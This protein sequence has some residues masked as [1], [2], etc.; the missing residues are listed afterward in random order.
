[1]GT[2][3]SPRQA[4]KAAAA[5]TGPGPK[6]LLQLA[7]LHRAR[8]ALQVAPKVAVIGDVAAMFGFSDWS[9]FSAS[10]NKLFGERPV[11]TRKRAIAVRN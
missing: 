5:V 1:M 6:S 3:L 7:R 2:Q 4:E 8:R 10:Y 9:Q 11:D